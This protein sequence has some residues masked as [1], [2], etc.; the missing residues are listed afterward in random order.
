MTMGKK[1][2]GRKGS[3]RRWGKKKEKSDK[4]KEGSKVRPQGVVALRFRRERDTQIA[5]TKPYWRKK[6]KK[7]AVVGKKFLHGM[8]TGH[9]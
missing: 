9:D 7:G 6:K 3:T 1:V 4:K 8:V 2:C 5:G